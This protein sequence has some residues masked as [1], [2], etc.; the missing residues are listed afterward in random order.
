MIFEY[1]KFRPGIITLGNLSMSHNLLNGLKLLKPPKSAIY[2]RFLRIRL[3]WIVS[4]QRTSVAPYPNTLE[5]SF[6]C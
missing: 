3:S 5:I 6:K 4:K 2:G 1:R